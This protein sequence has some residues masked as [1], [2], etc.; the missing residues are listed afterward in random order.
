MS[1]DRTL[2]AVVIAAVLTATACS[3]KIDER[4]VLGRYVANHG[5]GLDEIDMKQ[6]GTYSYIYRPSGGKEF[7][8]AEA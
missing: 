3:P 1:L 6:D 2:V 4:M 5:K 8:N 7:R